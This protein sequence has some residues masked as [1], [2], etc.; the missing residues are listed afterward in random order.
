[1]V[2]VAAGTTTAAPVRPDRP[3][4][5]SVNALH[6]MQANRS[7]SSLEIRFRRELWRQGVRGYRL[8]S[9]LPGRPDLVFSRLRLAVFVHG[10]FWHRCATCD[11]PWPKANAEFW[12]EKLLGNMA[13]DRAAEE[14]L[15][16][17]GWTPFIVW[18]HAL[19][20]DLEECATRLRTAVSSTAMPPATVAPSG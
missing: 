1:M 9:R 16:E 18:E 4:A 7:I 19:R 20:R 3:V 2:P 12:R 10:C 14:G 17:A 8:K 15:R 11:L 6:T 5:S 13:R